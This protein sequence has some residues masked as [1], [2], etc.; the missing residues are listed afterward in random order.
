MMSIYIKL[1]LLSWLDQMKQRKKIEKLIDDSV[2]LLNDT[3][4][5]LQDKPIEKIWRNE[6]MKNLLV[7]VRNGAVWLKQY[8][9]ET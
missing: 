9:R 7:N 6:N 1:T 5:I 3:E 2:F 8:M 4:I